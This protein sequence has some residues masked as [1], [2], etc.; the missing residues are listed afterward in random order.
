MG[1]DTAKGVLYL[2]GAAVMALWQSVGTPLVVLF[3]LMLLDTATAMIANGK[4][5]QLSPE[6]G[7]YGWRRKS[8]SLILV[9]AV[10]ILQQGVDPGILA[11]YGLQSLP[12][13]QSIAGIFAVMEGLSV[14][15]NYIYCGG[16][17]PESLQTALGV[18]KDLLTTKD[19]PEGLIGFLGQPKWYTMKG[20]DN[21]DA[22]SSTEQSGH[23]RGSVQGLRDERTEG[24][25]A[26]SPAGAPSPGAERGGGAWK[27]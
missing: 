15:R 6:A 5:K 2:M 4:L 23:E 9:L 24:V 8:T 12:A 14:V 3:L 27:V 17:L 26:D 21:G 1:E 25:R 16:Y 7:A 13:A 22:G 19:P 10:A 11:G 18:P 20:A